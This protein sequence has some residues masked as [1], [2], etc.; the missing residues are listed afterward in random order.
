MRSEDGGMD[1]EISFK[2]Y[3]FSQ[4]LPIFFNQTNDNNELLTKVNKR[5]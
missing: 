2:L 4:F 3:F 1:V 5:N